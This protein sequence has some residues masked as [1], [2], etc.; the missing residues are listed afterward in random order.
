MCVDL[1]VWRSGVSFPPW[2]SVH[3]PL[4]GGGGCD[5]RWTE[6]QLP[7]YVVGLSLPVFFCTKDTVGTLLRR[8][9]E[10]QICYYHIM[11]F[12]N[13]LSKGIFFFLFFVL[14]LSLKATSTN[15]YMLLI[16]TVVWPLR[17]RSPP[18]PLCR[19]PRFRIVA[20]CLVTSADIKAKVK[21][22]LGE[23]QENLN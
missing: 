14:S 4:L 18:P 19:A 15:N 10:K 1:A 17:P 7:N 21:R 23:S 8:Y 3:I 12:F 9:F 16:I 5:E 13:V 2:F 22:E 6:R 20:Q 11:Y